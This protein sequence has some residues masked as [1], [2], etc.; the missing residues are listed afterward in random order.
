MAS[1]YEITERFRNIAELLDNP[2]IPEEVLIDA[3]DSIEGEF[4][5]KATNIVRFMKSIEGDCKIIKEEEQRLASR[6]KALEAK[7]ARMKQYL[8]DSMKLINKTKFKTPFYSFNISANPKSIEILDEAIIPEK[9]KSYETICKIDKK[10]ILSD[11]KEN[12]IEVEGVKVNQTS[13]LKI[14]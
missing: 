14:R 5:D 1:L 13:S 2:E 11:M 12:N 6:R 4:E 9:Y 8:E 10:A 3:L 7:S